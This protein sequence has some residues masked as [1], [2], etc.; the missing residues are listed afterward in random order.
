MNITGASQEAGAG[1]QNPG[2]ISNPPPVN[3]QT[4]NAGTGGTDSVTTIVPAGSGPTFDTNIALNNNGGGGGT[5][6]RF[7]QYSVTC[8][9]INPPKV[10]IKKWVTN[11]NGTTAFTFDG[12]PLPQPLTLT[13]GS[14]DT[15]ESSSQITLTAGTPY[16]ITEQTPAAPWAFN[17]ASC[18]L[19]AGPGSLV[20]SQINGG[21]S[22]TPAAN[23]E[24]TCN[25]Y[26]EIDDTPPKL[27]L[28]KWVT[29][30]DGQTTFTFNGI[31]PAVQLMPGAGDT[32]EASSQITLTAGQVYNLTEEAPASPWMFNGASCTLDAGPGSLVSSQINEG[33][34]ITPA[35]GQEITCNFYNEID[36]GQ[37]PVPPKLIIKKTVTN[38]DGQTTFTF[39]G[40]TPAVQLTPGSGDTFE[41]SS[42]ITL[43][44]GTTYN[45]TEQMPLDPDWSFNG[46]SCSLDAGPGPL[47]SSQITDGVSI[48]PADDQEITCTFD[49]EKDDTPDPGELIIEKISIGGTQSFSILAD[50]TAD[51]TYNITTDTA[52]VPKSLS[53]AVDADTYTISE[54]PPSGWQ[55]VS[56]D[57]VGGQSQGTTAVVTAGGPATT[58]TVVNKK[59]NDDTTDDETKRFIHRRVDNLLTY[60]PDRARMLRRL[61]EKDP[62]QQSL[63]DGPLKHSSGTTTA[64]GAGQMAAFGQAPMGLGIS[65]S[66]MNGGSSA[67]RI[68]MSSGATPYISPFK[69]DGVTYLNENDE[70]ATTPFEQRTTSSL[71]SQLA[72]QFMPLA[73]GDN[74]F[75]FSTSLSEIRSAAAAAEEASERAKLEEAGLS[76][77]GQYSA[78]R[79]ATLRDTFDVWVEGHIAKYNDNIGG[80]RREGD[81]R[82]LY[83]GADYVVADGI[84]IG[85]L[86]QIDD[87]EEDLDD[88]SRQGEIEGT[89]WMVGPYVGVRLRDNLFF[90]ARAAWG[91]SDNDIWIVDANG[92]RTGS[93][94]TDRWIASASLTGNEYVDAWRFSPQLKVAYGNEQSD[95]YVT[96]LGQIVSG[97]DATIGRLTGTMEVGY[98]LERADGTLIEPHVAISGIWNFDA[99]DLSFNGTLYETDEARAKVEGGILIYT[100]AGWGL[101]AAGAYDGIGASDFDAY[102]G[103]LWV[104]V[105]LN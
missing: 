17:G 28:K 58:C 40:L 75:K 44:A 49:N 46:A 68:G 13:P 71:F 27:T 88:P 32:F 79:F 9:P 5:R 59:I 20:S 22:I 105:P 57:C 36:D 6:F 43:T 47:V 81:F 65:G 93:F 73:T 61:R 53:Q 67:Y 87:T 90:D 50:G 38:G 80:I 8:T 89:G 52:G 77:D 97:T 55:L 39:N 64:D 56:I 23:Q 7:V 15:S 99:D 14:G 102:S 51:Y 30:G 48:T 104:N 31:T 96:S 83:V 70:L 103:S 72:A 29:N 74:A 12:L 4:F 91:Q 95:A 33:V 16:N 78:G 42:Q 101:R 54:T 37:N 41:T 98:R 63:K 62:P 85:A 21:V 92:D 35:A 2:G 19:D 11:G 69:Y 84:L 86:V 66:A 60:G 34:S 94:D 10:T 100:P 76:F 24:I 18:T 45:L 25:F 3:D 1:N 26:N 82:I